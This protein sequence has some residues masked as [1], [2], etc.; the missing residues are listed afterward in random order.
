MTMMSAFSYHAEMSDTFVSIV[1][2]IV[3]SF[4]SDFLTLFYVNDTYLIYI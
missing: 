4:M 3:H 2:F 1:F